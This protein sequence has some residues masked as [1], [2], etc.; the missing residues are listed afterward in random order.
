[1]RGVRYG[2][3]QL[4]GANKSWPLFK[5]QRVT[6]FSDVNDIPT[7]TGVPSGHETFQ[8]HVDLLDFRSLL[9]ID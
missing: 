8:K 9:R 5:R 2:R 3:K 7:G 1:M 4:L 6:A